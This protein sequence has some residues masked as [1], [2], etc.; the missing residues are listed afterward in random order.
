MRSFESRSKERRCPISSFF[1]RH[2]NGT[3]KTTSFVTRRFYRTMLVPEEGLEPSQPQG[4][5]DFES[6]ASTDFATPAARETLLISPEIGKKKSREKCATQGG[7]PAL[8][9]RAFTPAILTRKE[10]E[11]SSQSAHGGCASHPDIQRTRA[12]L[13]KERLEVARPHIVHETGGEIGSQPADVPLR[14]ASSSRRRR[15]RRSGVKDFGK[16]STMSLGP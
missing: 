6:G 1:Q 5:P 12:S 14:S 16:T 10:C 8:A 13:A 4:P 11:Y 7:H 9:L 2:K 3:K 15:P